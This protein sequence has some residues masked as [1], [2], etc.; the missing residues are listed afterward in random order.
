MG[1]GEFLT[2]LGA[3]LQANV[4]RRLSIKPTANRVHTVQ[5]GL[6]AADGVGGDGKHARV[7]ARAV[8][9]NYLEL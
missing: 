7:V 4:R 5:L 6:T 8:R 3:M 2:L 1:V 9:L